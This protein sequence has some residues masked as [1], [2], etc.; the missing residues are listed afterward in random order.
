MNP[1][2]S[3]SSK[4]GQQGIAVHRKLETNGNVKA[5]S[6]KSTVRVVWCGPNCC[7]SSHAQNFLAFLVW[8]HGDAVTRYP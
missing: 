1:I 3:V 4:R 5:L 6:E 2:H 8:P 7:S